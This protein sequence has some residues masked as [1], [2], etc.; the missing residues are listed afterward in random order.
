MRLGDCLKVTLHT[1]KNN[2]SRS[3]LTVA[4][5]T[6]ISTL[7]IGM[8]S[9]AISFSSNSKDLINQAYF[10]KSSMVTVEY[11]NKKDF[12]APQQKIFT[13]DYYDSFLSIADEHQEVIDFIQYESNLIDSPI[14]FTEP[15][16][17]KTYG[18]NIISGRHINTSIN[19]N[20]VIVSKT[21]YEKSLTD[22]DMTP[23]EIGTTHEKEVMYMGKFTERR[24]EPLTTKI[25]YV[26]VGIFE[27]PDDQSLI[28]N[29]SKDFIK[30]GSI[31]GD[32]GILFNIDSKDI[33]VA[34]AIMYHESQGDISNP[35]STINEL[36]SVKDS[37]NKTLPKSVTTEYFDAPPFGEIMVF[38]HDG[39]SCNVFEKYQENNAIRYIVVGVAVFF[40]IILLLISIGS[41]VNSVLISI[42]GSKRFMGLL[43]A[44]GMHNK[45]LVAIFVLES[46]LLVS[47]GTLLGYILLICLSNPLSSLMNLIVSFTYSAYMKVTTFAV[48]I[49]LPVYIFFTALVVFLLLTYLFSRGALYKTVKANPYSVINEVN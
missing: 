8:V 16:Y 26:V 49:Q 14:D 32:I 27:A 5:A 31:I 20:E 34:S 45:S 2:R 21:L 4:I 6:F 48:S 29:G 1:I 10:S 46:L 35:S 17:P 13:K 36:N 41:L 39:A 28:I 22:P 43:K 23:L 9:L 33:H 30:Y 11:H 44:L 42:S 40:S 15:K 38:Y 18:V 12:N 47:V 24:Y 25:E 7:I 37:L 19:H 3:L